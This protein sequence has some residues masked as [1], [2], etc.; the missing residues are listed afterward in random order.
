[1][2]ECR[3]VGDILRAVHLNPT[4]KEVNK[5]IQEIDP[6][7]E[8]RITF[9]EFLPIY[10]SQSTKDLGGN[11]EMFAEV[12]SVFDREQNGMI[13]VAEL[14]HVLTG[15]GEVMSNKEVEILC[16]GMENDDGKINYEDF[17]RSVLD[18]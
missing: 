17:I 3:Y 11:F 9:E 16:H 13:N 8:K 4:Q 12:F 18:G 2:V 5:I 14:R 10:H 15:L 7:G 6:T 1:M